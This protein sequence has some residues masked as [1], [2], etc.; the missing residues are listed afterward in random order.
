MLNL[1]IPGQNGNT[2]VYPEEL[3]AI[4]T[5]L[6][7]WAA[8]RGT[9]LVFALT[10]TMLCNASADGCVVANNNK[11]RAIM[12]SLGIPTFSLHDA[13]VAKCGPAPQPSCLGITGCFCPHCSSVGYQW[14]AESTVAPAIRAMLGAEGAAAALQ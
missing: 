1:T 14:L 12:Q 8:P 5:R 11:A 13:I 6:Q 3:Q 10:S 4:A 2:S 9:K 7:A